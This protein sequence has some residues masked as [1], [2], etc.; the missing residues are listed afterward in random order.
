MVGR[1]KP[2]PNLLIGTM[3]SCRCPTF[4]LKGNRPL[5]YGP[6]WLSKRVLHHDPPFP[7]NNLNYARLRSARILSDLKGH[8]PWAD[9]SPHPVSSRG[10][11]GHTPICQKPYLAE[12]RQGAPTAVYRPNSLGEL[13]TFGVS[14][15]GEGQGVLE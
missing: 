4:F 2:F 12:E 7:H 9:S 8:L 6:T 11:V 10:F 15:D 5:A 3:Y 1:N 13:G 14:R